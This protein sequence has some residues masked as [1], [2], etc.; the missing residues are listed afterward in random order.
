[1]NILYI[2][3]SCDPYAG[4]EDKTGWNVPLENSKFHNV[5]VITKEEHRESIDRYLKVNN[6]TN[7][8]FW[9]VDIP[10]FYKKIFKGFLYSG[11]LNIWHRRVYQVAKKICVEKNINI[12]HQVTPLEFRSIGAYGKIKGN[13]F[14]CGPLGGAEYVPFALKEYIG[15]HKSVE[16]FRKVVNRFYYIKYMINGRIRA[17]DFLI[18]ANKET[19]EYLNK[20]TKNI[21]SRIITDVGIGVN[22][23]KKD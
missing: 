21:P 14:V 9:Y 18:Y 8:N 16:I 6:E 19:K 12:I 3:Y 7:V 23:I 10:G 17:C 4:S 2:A 5:Y 11:R 15:R 1:M 20:L 13:K 22:E